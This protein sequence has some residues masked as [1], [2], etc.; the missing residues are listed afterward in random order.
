MMHFDMKAMNITVH[1]LVDEGVIVFEA[2]VVIHHF[3]NTVNN[4]RSY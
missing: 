3:L 4:A 1:Y 2:S